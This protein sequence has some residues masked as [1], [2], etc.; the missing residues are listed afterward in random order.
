MARFNTSAATVT[1]TVN[2]AGGE[3]FVESP[4]VEFAS[5]LLTS[6]VSDQAYRPADAGIARVIELLDA[7]PPLFAAK[8]AVYARNE[9]GMRSISHVVAGELALRVRGEQWT[10]PF[11]RSVVRRPDDI[12]EIVSYVIAKHGRRPLPNAMKDGLGQAFAKFD[13]YQLAK[14][15]SADKALSLVDV[16][17][18][19][20]PKPVEQNAKALKALVA[21]TLRSEY[22]WEAK[23][24]EA[25]KAPSEE[26]QIEAKAEA[27]GELVRS[28]KIGY[29]ALL[30]NLRNIMQQAPDA[31]PAALDILVDEGMIRSSLVLPFR[32]MTAAAEIRTEAGARPVL[33]ALSQAAEI[34]LG[35][36]PR[37]DGRTLIA[38]DASGS[39][40]S[41]RVGRGKTVVA[42]AAAL[43]AAVLYKRNDADLMLFAN[44]ATI[45]NVSPDA[46]VLGL[47]QAIRQTMQGGGTNFRSIFQT[48]SVAYDRVVI[49]SD[50]QGWVGHDAPTDTFEAYVV[51]VGKRPHVYSFDLA[52]MGTLQFP[53]Q[54]VYCL[55]GFSD[56][57]FEMM[58]MLEADK[59][60]LIKRIEAVDFA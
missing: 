7:V 42:D 11:F 60:A 2:L 49:L 5:I 57:A 22:T 25:G 9:Y 17:N 41:A 38:V 32:F 27:W 30:R 40:T 50:M 16:V 36:V 4:A 18:L 43:F 6:M 47:Q 3:A 19:L 29:F 8:A 48:A 28:R 35:N 20:H 53:Q 54:Q 15:R 34:S 24:S 13:E 56:R 1:R 45:A 44:E 37:F 59:G 33:A 12:T 31:L 14:Y 26:A 39:M 51:R 23:L 58:Q 52:G 21:G 55:A 10:R 46:G